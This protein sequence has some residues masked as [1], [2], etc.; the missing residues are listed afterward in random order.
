MAAL[1]GGCFLWARFPCRRTALYS[2]AEVW[3]Q[4]LCERRPLGDTCVYLGSRTQ[5]VSR[6][7]TSLSTM[8]KVAEASAEVA[9]S[10]RTGLERTERSGRVLHGYL[11][12][13]KH[14][15]PRTLQQDYT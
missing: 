10:E 3:A 6:G 7:T 9:S 11:A 4:N 1:G 15:P 13:K 12:H 14:P 5:L 8:H 2:R